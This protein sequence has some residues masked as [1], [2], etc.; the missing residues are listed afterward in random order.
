MEAFVPKVESTGNAG[1]CLVPEHSSFFLWLALFVYLLHV[2]GHR[3]TCVLDQMLEIKGF[4][5]FD[6]GH[7]Y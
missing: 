3:S 2:F 5:C 6:D 7:S 4:G 1:W